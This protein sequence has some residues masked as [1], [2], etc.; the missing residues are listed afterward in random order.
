MGIYTRYKRSP[1]GLRQLVELLETAP[2][3]RRQKMIE[4]GMAEDP[5]YTQ[6]AMQYMMTF[7]DAEKLP[8]MELAEVVSA[9]P[10]RMV[11]IAFSR[12]PQE[13]KDRV[14]KCANPRSG[15]EIR[16]LI[17]N[18]VDPKSVGGAQSKVV[19][20]MRKLEKKGVVKA[21]R[22]PS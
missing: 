2:S 5:D 16:D 14:L 15:A 8:D 12:S 6:L 3:V 20:N 10:A 4:V 18:E 21:K 7:A 17:N 13:L 19:E 1:D 11:A 9:V 22:V